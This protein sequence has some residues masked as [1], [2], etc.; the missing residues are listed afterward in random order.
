MH[1]RDRNIVVVEAYSGL[2][3]MHTRFKSIDEEMSVSNQDAQKEGLTGSPPNGH[4]NIV[5]HTEIVENRT[6]GRCEL[7]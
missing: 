5:P 6:A 1:H 4:R 3:A 2:Q 7:A